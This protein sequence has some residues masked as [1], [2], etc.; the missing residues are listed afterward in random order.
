MN[1]ISIQLFALNIAVIWLVSTRFIYDVKI[2]LK[3]VFMPHL[4]KEIIFPL[5]HELHQLRPLAHNHSISLLKGLNSRL[6]TAEMQIIASSQQSASRLF[7][8]KVSYAP[9]GGAVAKRSLC[10]GRGARGCNQQFIETQ[11]SI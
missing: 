8:F 1:F 10:F 9:Q 11:Q 2:L 7:V 4:D 5:M 6:F 3:T